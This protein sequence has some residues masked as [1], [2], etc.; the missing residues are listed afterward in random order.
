MKALKRQFPVMNPT[1]SI[2]D[3][4]RHL[5]GEPEHFTC[6]AG[7][8]F[9]YLD[10]HL[11]LYRCHNWERPL[12]HISEFDGTQRLR[13]GCTACMID[14]YRDDSVM[15]HAG[16]AVSD[17]IGA[18]ADRHLGEAW[19]HW[20][21]RKNLTSVRA[22]LED[23]PPWRRQVQRSAQRR[24]SSAPDAR[25]GRRARGRSLPERRDDRAVIAE[26]EGEAVGIE[27]WRL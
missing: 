24:T 26:N 20:F 4:Q 7:W 19:K 17:G 6:L 11:D 5:R 22:V 21:S 14:C 18:A 27:F 10:W 13:D 25:R 8:K 9:F 2:D 3:M 23:A 1:A 16:V 12:C 15:Q